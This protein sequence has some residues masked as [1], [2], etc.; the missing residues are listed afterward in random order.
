LTAPQGTQAKY[1]AD[2]RYDGEHD[3]RGEMK[4]WFWLAVARM[5]ECAT[6]HNRKY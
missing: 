3:D 6:T 5:S 4:V 1:H 2:D